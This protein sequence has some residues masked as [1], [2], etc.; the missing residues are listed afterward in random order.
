MQG[1]HSRYNGFFGFLSSGQHRSM[2]DS[3][4]GAASWRMKKEKS[5]HSRRT[6]RK[7]LCCTPQ[8][9]QLKLLDIVRKRWTCHKW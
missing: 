4:G 1:K 6:E 8:N 7:G 5:Q 2:K 9:H 3:G